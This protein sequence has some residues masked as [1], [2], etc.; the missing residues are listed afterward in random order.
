M[1]DSGY[2]T[3]SDVKGVKSLVCCTKMKKKSCCQE[4]KSPLDIKLSLPC[5]LNSYIRAGDIKMYIVLVKNT[6]IPLLRYLIV[7]VWVKSMPLVQVD[8]LF[9]FRRLFYAL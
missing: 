4:K 7:T 8:S 2:F 9:P 1:V 5:G 3:T 6:S